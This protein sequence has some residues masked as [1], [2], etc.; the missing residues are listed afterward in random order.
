MKEFSIA[1]VF[2]CIGIL[3]GFFCGVGFSQHAIDAGEMEVL[4]LEVLVG[5]LREEAVLHG[6]A[7]WVPSP[8]SG[9]MQFEWNPLYEIVWRPSTASREI[10]PYCPGPPPDDAF[11]P[12]V[13]GNGCQDNL[14]PRKEK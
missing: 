10:Y 1:G 4:Q 13:L 7:E 8:F 5:D 3:I 14:P 12:R 11:L 6:V 2:A 9:E